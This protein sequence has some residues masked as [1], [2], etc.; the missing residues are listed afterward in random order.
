MITVYGVYE[1]PVGT[2]TSQQLANKDLPVIKAAY[3]EKA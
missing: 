1:F 2:Q 3:I